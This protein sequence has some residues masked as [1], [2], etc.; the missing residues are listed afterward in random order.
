M[1]SADPARPASPA[2]VLAASIGLAV[3]ALL[4]HAPNKL[5][6]DVSYFAASGRYLNDGAR[7]YVD[8]ID[9]NTPAPSGLGRISDAWAGWLGLPLDIAH[10]ITLTA[11]GLDSLTIAFAGV[12]ARRAGGWRWGSPPPC[13][14][15]R[16]SSAAASI[17]SR[18][19]PAAGRCRS[20]WLFR[21]CAG[22]PPWRWR[23]DWPPGWGSF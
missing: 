17:C 9:F 22:P 20:H 15:R 13:C 8:W 10:R 12:R 14:W 19:P 5:D 6:H 18:P 4:L 16:R 23:P 1:S 11:L 3:A 2:P 7:L 21:A